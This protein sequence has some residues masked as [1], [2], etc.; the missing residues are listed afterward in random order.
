MRPDTCCHLAYALL[1]FITSQIHPGRASDEQTNRNGDFF[2]MAH[3]FALST[4]AHSAARGRGIPK[5]SPCLLVCS[6]DARPG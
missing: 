4:P 3:F 1:C 6:S 2:W 5:K